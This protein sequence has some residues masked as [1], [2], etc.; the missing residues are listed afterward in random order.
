M[1][2]HLAAVV[3][4]ALANPIISAAMVGL[5]VFLILHFAT[6]IYLRKIHAQRRTTDKVIAAS[7]TNSR[8]GETTRCLTK[9]CVPASVE[10]LSLERSRGL[11]RSAHP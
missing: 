1:T 7:D 6:A 10:L 2:D 4:A 11:P 9:H 3:A 8:T 5:G